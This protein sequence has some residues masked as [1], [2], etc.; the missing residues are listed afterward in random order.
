[1]SWGKKFSK[2]AAPIKLHFGSKIFGYLKKAE[3]YLE[4]FR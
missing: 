4:S 3:L 2:E 1:M